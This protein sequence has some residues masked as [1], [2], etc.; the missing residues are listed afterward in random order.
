MPILE[1]TVNGETVALE[2]DGLRTLVDVI[3]DDL[4]LTGTKIG[5]REGECGACTVL[6]DGDAVNACLL[7]AMRAHHRT[8][9]TIEGIGGMEN[10]HPVQEAL[11]E[12]GGIQCGY[13]TP[14]IVM[15]GVSLLRKTPHPSEEDVIEAIE[16]NLC[17]CTGYVRIVEGILAASGVRD[18]DGRRRSDAEAAAR[19]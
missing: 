4:G 9:E 14:G 18:L 1:T 2:I 15:S 12:S 8:V 3:R 13:C 10:P 7:P 16:G 6:L 17:R 19:D 5:C 11:V